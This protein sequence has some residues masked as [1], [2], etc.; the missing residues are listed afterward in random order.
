[1]NLAT[2]RQRIAI[3]RALTGLFDSAPV[4]LVFIFVL[5]EQ[6]FFGN[7]DD[8][9]WL[10]LS[11]SGDPTDLMS[12]TTVPGLSQIE[13]GTMRFISQ[14]IIFPIYWAASLP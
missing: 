2:D 3:R 1:M 13:N 5:T 14:L 9:I 8:S 7:F 4:W 6:P 10:R 12:G 11:S